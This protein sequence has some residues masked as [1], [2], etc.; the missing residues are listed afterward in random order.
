MKDKYAYTKLSDFIQENLK[1]R[2]WAGLDF[3]TM[4]GGIPKSVGSKII[5]GKQGP[6]F[7]QIVSLA[8]MFD[9][10]VVDILN[11]R[12]YEEV[13]D[14]DMA[15]C[16]SAD[17]EKLIDIFKSVPVSELIAHHWVGVKDRNDTQEM[18]RVFAPYLEEA[19]STKALAHKTHA[20]DLKL[21]NIQKAW[22]LRVRFLARRMTTS[23]MFCQEN[24]L[25]VVEELKY[26]MV[27]QKDFR[28]VVS[29]LDRAGIRLVLVECKKS[30]IDAVCTWLDDHS[31][32]IGMTLR[33]DRIDNFWFI[34][35]HELSHVEQ[36]FDI[37]PKIDEN[38][39][40]GVVNG[41]EAEA[42]SAAQEFCA[43]KKLV[44]EYLEKSQGKITEDEVKAF[45]ENNYILPAAMAGQIRFRLS[46]Y[47]ILSRL[48]VKYRENLLR[49]AFVKDGWGYVNT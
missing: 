20:E 32:V 4:L 1:T 16:S 15:L 18:L 39:E 7:R 45:A 14:S 22:L 46:K 24:M 40:S 29:I 37:N 33:F 17:E 25:S 30:K 11:M 13:C 26:A 2:G 27:E 41:L 19:N 38:I 12:L 31:P 21:T 8:R 43:P 28:E 48:M 44:D 23:G 6:T 42:S 10:R 9:V 47:N 34:L 35:R 36:G 3:C 49:A 5:N